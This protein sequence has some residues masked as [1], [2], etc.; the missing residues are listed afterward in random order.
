MTMNMVT[1]HSVYGIY[2][3][4]NS[5]HIFSQP[6]SSINNIKR[7]SIWHFFA[8]SRAPQIDLALTQKVTYNSCYNM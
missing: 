3:A 7:H 6:C 4:H 2:I 8:T 5:G 1:H